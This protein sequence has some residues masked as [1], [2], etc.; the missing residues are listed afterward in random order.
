[1]KTFFLAEN[2]GNQIFCQSMMQDKVSVS[3]FVFVFVSVKA[4]YTTQALLLLVWCWLEMNNKYLHTSLDH[5]LNF[6]MFGDKNI[7]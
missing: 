5:P 1:M 3:V 6:G 2:F 7:V 4:K